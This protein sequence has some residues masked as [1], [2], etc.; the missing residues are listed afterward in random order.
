MTTRSP[1][2]TVAV[3]MPVKDE[4]A[5]IGAAVRSAVRSLEQAQAGAKATLGRPFH[6]W[7]IVVDDGCTDDTI[8]RARAAAEGSSAVTLSVVS[9]D[10]GQ[11]AGARMAG[12]ALVSATAADPTSVWILSTDGDC[13]VPPDWVSRYLA[14]AGAG[15]SAVAGVVDLIDCEWVEAVGDRW[16]ADYRAEFTDDARH[17][18]VHAANLGVRLDR[19]LAVGGFRPLD[20][21]EDI[22]L[23]TRLRAAGVAPRADADL[24]VGTS[25]R[26][27]GR[28]ERGFAHALDVMYGAVDA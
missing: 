19:Y 26:T 9:T 10:A 1:V 12:I 4:Q 13:V 21:A 6:P 17:P 7:L 2:H 28:V 22:D 14:H 15:S 5:R 24:V 23:W 11:A 3:V 8:A 25:A 20:R 16:R 18:H 27:T